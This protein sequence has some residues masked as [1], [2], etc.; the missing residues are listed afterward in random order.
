MSPASRLP[1]RH[2]AGL[3]MERLWS[4]RAFLGL[5][6][7]VGAAATLA[8]AGCTSSAAWVNPD[9]A[10]VRDRERQRGGTGKTTA[11]TLTAASASLDLAGTTAQT[12]AYGAVPAPIIRLSAGDTLKATIRNQLPVETSVHW[13]GLALRNDMDGVPPLT[14]QPIAAG[15]SFDYEFIAPDPGTYWFH[16]HVGAQLD[17]GLYGALIIEDPNEPLAYDDEWV[18]VLDDWLDGVTAT[19]DE[20]LAE[21]SRGMGDMGGMDDMF[22]RMGNTL[23]GATSDLLGG[24][25][26]DVYYPHYL[27]NG[28]PAAD[29]AQFTGTPG[30]RVR[31]RLINA[32]GDTAFRIAIGGHRL[33]VTHTDGFP[34]ESVEVDSVLLG[35]GERYDLLVTLGDGA[36]PLVAQAEG[37]RERAFAVV[38]TG[39]GGAPPQDAV[40]SELD[41][42]QVGTA[43]IL[44]ATT[45][46][47]LDAKAADREITLTLTGSMADYDWGINGQRFDP[48]QPLRDAHAVRAGERVRLRMVN[49]TEM[50]HPFH[51]HG[52]T[53]QHSDGGPRKDTSIILPKQTLTVDFDADNPGQWAAHCHNIYHA[54]T[55]M[56]TVIG[57]QT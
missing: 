42:D 50:W 39:G 41:S 18:I 14:Q 53:Y 52:H 28:K 32:G 36:F 34:V 21:L 19:P 15:S 40:L 57:Y 54:E 22:M 16:P 44:T 33:T 1:I 11:V 26:G 37:K 3:G 46:V 17:S 35:M 25:A 9:S 27:I 30:S 10:A 47:A 55:G 51:L 29:P 12:F 5:G 31:I 48:T 43:A 4:R 20:V 8:L 23:M 56:M 38:R 45:G 6:L 7:G 49:E 13:H 24:D 2:D